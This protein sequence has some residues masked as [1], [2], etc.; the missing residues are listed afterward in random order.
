M[1]GSVDGIGLGAKVGRRELGLAVVKDLREFRA[2]PS[3]QD[4][5]DFETDTLRR[6][7]RAGKPHRP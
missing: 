2:E 1:L 5:E 6:A 3:G 7:R 4:L